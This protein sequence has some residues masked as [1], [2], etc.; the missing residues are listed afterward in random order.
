MG[1][2]PKTDMSGLPGQCRADPR[3]S[4]G[5]EVTGVATLPGPVLAPPSL[6]LVLVGP[7]RHESAYS[8]WM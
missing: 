1:G 3:D 7:V 4:E 6:A 8:M 2:I 5:M